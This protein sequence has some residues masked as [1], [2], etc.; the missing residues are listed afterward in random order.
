MSMVRPRPPAG[1][2]AS[3]SAGVSHYEE[4][5]GIGAHTCGVR[6]DGTI[7]CWGPDKSGQNAPPPGAFVAIGSSPMGYTCALDAAG[8]TTCWG[9]HRTAP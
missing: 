9:S 5:L 8:A 4:E 7:A 1:T 6:A 2:F 3:V